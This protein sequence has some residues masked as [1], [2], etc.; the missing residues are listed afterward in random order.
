MNERVEALFGV[1]FVLSA[2]AS[3]GVAAVEVFDV[4][5][6]TV[7]TEVGPLTIDY[8]TAVSV[9]AI[10][11]AFYEQGGGVTDFGAME[12]IYLYS[13]I[14]MVGLTAW[15]AYDPGFAANQDVPVQLGLL[16]VTI[17]G[18]WGLAHH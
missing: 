11:V 2:A 3:L 6:L 12:P 1:A 14:A 4:E 10:A 13:V 7:L 8:A 5:L 18:Y 17:M 15:G 16:A 9:A